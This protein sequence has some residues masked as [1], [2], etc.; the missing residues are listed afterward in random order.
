MY[1]VSGEWEIGR[2]V[3]GSSMASD[4]TF[5]LYIHSLDLDV[6]SPI[7]VISYILQGIWQR[8]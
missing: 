7:R 5:R 3:L 1:A 8:L 6:G 2:D 4:C